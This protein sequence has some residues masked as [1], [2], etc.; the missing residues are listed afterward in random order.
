MEFALQASLAQTENPAYRILF[1]FLAIF[2]QQKICAKIVFFK[3]K[4]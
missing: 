1:Y 3:T 4:D 2:A